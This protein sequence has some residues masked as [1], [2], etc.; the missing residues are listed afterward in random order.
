MRFKKVSVAATLLCLVFIRARTPLSVDARI[1]TIAEAAFTREDMRQKGENVVFGYFESDAHQDAD[2]QGLPFVSLDRPYYSLTATYTGQL[3]ASKGETISITNDSFRI[4]GEDY[5]NNTFTLA[6]GD[7]S[8]QPSVLS[9]GQNPLVITY[10]NGSLK[11]ELKTNITIY[12]VEVVGTLTSISVS[13]KHDVITYGDPLDKARYTVE[14]I[15]EY[16]GIDYHVIYKEWDCNYNP[17]IQPIKTATWYQERS[18]D[19]VLYK[20]DGSCVKTDL[21]LTIIPEEVICEN[22]H[23]YYKEPD[24]TD[25]GCPICKNTPT[26][27]APVTQPVRIPQW[28]PKPAVTMLVTYMDGHK[29]YHTEGFSWDGLDTT[30]IGT[31]NAT[32]YMDGTEISKAY[33][34]EIYE[35]PDYTASSDIGVIDEPIRNPNAGQVIIDDG[36][37]TEV[38][39]GTAYYLPDILKHLDQHGVQKFNSGSY[40]TIKVTIDGKV[41]TAGVQIK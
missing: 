9:I 21:M 33:N 16:D 14:A 23:H 35:D 11:F 4:S 3:V 26:D 6:E 31:Q 1:E 17:T 41:Y 32:I 29:E 25:L 34:V 7:Y 10:Y 28:T 36:S 27:F 30:V 19:V 8:I 37:L 20:S 2:S 12:D 24:G 40:V 22:G 15:Y 39:V 18:F 5:F 13:P 38:F